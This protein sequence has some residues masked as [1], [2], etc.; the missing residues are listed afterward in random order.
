[1]ENDDSLVV[2]RRSIKANDNEQLMTLIAKIF[3]EREDYL[4]KIQ[5]LEADAQ[6]YQILHQQIVV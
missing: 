3:K 4:T 1:M 5:G 2:L 6:R